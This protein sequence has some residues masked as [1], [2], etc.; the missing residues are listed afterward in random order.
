[1]KKDNNKVNF[2]LSV[3]TLEQLIEVYEKINEFLVY[4]DESK[5]ELEGKE[6]N[7]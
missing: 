6:S 2:D 7:E 1:M 3:L 5:I 4:L